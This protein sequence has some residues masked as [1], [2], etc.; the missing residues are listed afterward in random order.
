MFRPGKK[1]PGL[2]PNPGKGNP[3]PGPGFPNPNPGTGIGL[4]NPNPGTGFP[5]PNPGT[6]FPNPNPGT[7]NPSPGK[8]KGQPSALDIQ[9]ARIN[10]GFRR[11]VANQTAQN[12]YHSAEAPWLFGQS[13]SM[14][15]PMNPMMMDPWQMM[16]PMMNSM[17]PWMS[18]N[19]MMNSMNPISGG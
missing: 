14:M 15:N 17:N 18:M 3:N 5:N 2:P 8:G 16:N 9:Q 7:G 11:I 1:G 4:P 6:G 19:P 12:F 13:N 10:D